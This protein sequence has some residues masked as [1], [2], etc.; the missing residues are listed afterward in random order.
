VINILTRGLMI[1]CVLAIFCIV[2]ES[3]KLGAWFAVFMA[4]GFGIKVGIDAERAE[5][6]TAP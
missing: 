2:A 1:G 4:Y 6:G 3:T 5:K